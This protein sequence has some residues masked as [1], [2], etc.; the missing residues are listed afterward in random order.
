MCFRFFNAYRSI[1]AIRLCAS[2][3]HLLYILYTTVYVLYSYAH[4]K[5]AK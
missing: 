3:P 4:S 5:R 2:V 1:T